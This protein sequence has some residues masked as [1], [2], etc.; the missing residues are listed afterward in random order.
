MTSQDV[1][2]L[3]QLSSFITQ[4][5]NDHAVTYPVDEYQEELS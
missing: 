2:T 1:H 5:E 3:D 4:L